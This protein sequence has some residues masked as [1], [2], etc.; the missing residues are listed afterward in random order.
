M[1]FLGLFCLSFLSSHA[2]E[3]PPIPPPKNF[4]ESRPRTEF[5]AALSSKETWEPLASRESLA[6]F[7][8][9]KTVPEEVI[10]AFE[11]LQQTLEK[12]GGPSKAELGH[13]LPT[14]VRFLK[15]GH[16]LAFD[17]ETTSFLGS[18]E[19]GHFDLPDRV[20]LSG[21]LMGMDP[22]LAAKTLAHELQHV[23][24]QYVQRTWPA[25][26]M[27]MRGQKVSILVLRLLMTAVPAKFEDIRRGKDDDQ[28][29][30]LR[31]FELCSRAYDAGP[32]AFA[33][34]IA[35]GPCD[36]KVSV[37]PQI[38]RFSLKNALDPDFGDPAHL[39]A[40]LA[41][42][43][44]ERE[45]IAALNAER[46]RL[47]QSLRE[48]WS[49]PLDLR[50]RD[51]EDD[52]SRAQMEYYSYERE[53]VFKEVLI[54]RMTAERAWLKLKDGPQAEYDLRLTVDADYLSP[55]ADPKSRSSKP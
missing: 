3:P 36:A 53:A 25:E 50:L 23:Y 22:L 18:T 44:F 48:K 6:A 43:E 10:P 12:A 19:H 32:H 15:D 21:K 8:R 4:L 55:P 49:R 29:R 39:E 13:L 40:V 31:Q 45:S 34:A 5:F 14:A 30:M 42:M 20:V 27:E 52:L 11:A 38:A 37:T 26:V 35:F 47:R 1:N 51:V 16:T 17:K 24:D 33:R 46:E 54:R 2:V 7:L 9:E 28:R 41:A